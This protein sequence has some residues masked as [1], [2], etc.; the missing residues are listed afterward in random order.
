VQDS[1]GAVYSLP[2]G[3]LLADGRYHQLVTDLS[4]PAGRRPAYPL[5]LLGLSLDYQLPEFPAPPY[6]T[7]GARRAALGAERRAAATPAMLDIRGL[8]VSPATSGTFPADFAGP[9]RLRGWHAAASSVILADPKI[10]R[11]IQPSVAS[12]RVSAAAATLALRPGA[13]DLIQVAGAPVLPVTGQL[14]LTAGSPALPVPGVA[15]SAFLAA[16]GAR[17]GATISVPVGNATVPV[18]LAAA[19]RAFPAAGSSGPVLVVDLGWMGQ[20]LTAQSQ[21]PLPVTQWWLS[22]SRGRVPRG[23]P[24]GATVA[25]SAGAAARLLGDPL[26]NIPQQSLLAIVV[27]AGALAGIG[28]VVS[29]VA[30]LRERSAQTALLAALGVS[31]A[32]RA[33]Q[34]CLEQL[35]LSV[36]GAAAGA[37]IGVALA[38]LLVPAGTLTAGASAPFP[39]VHVVIPLGWTALLAL[40]IAAVPALAAVLTVAYRPDPAAGLRAGETG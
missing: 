20:V 33:G 17:V 9:D 5:H 24:A 38:Y 19:V 3:T 39:P 16:A 34:L 2:V 4:G 26:P 28:F 31:R 6:G 37:V 32:A 8:A 25:S 13:G 22:T 14:T 23:L 15:T 30:A 10:T 40:G 18:R 35:L 27:A 29:V 21:P 7:G 1:S 12:W 36:P 11:G